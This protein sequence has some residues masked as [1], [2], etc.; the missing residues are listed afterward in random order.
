VVLITILKKAFQYANKVLQALVVH[1]LAASE[2]SATAAT[3]LPFAAVVLV[4][5]L[6]GLFFVEQA[7]ASADFNLLRGW[8]SHSCHR[9]GAEIFA[10]RRG[11]DYRDWGQRGLL[12]LLALHGAL[13]PE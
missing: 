4:C 10:T 3:V 9:T 1:I 6:A 8:S 5:F 13:L 11:S 2:L 12:Y 7:C